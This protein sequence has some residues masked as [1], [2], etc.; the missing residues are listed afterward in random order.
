MNNEIFM[1]GKSLVTKFV[2]VFFFFFK[3]KINFDKFIIKLHLL[4]VSFTFV[5]FLIK[6]KVNSYVINI[7]FKLKVFV[8]KKYT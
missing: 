6:L 8:I 2:I 5:K 1:K 4:F 3:L 7:L